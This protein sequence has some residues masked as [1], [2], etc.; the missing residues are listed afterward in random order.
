MEK[1]D[2]FLTE[3]MGECWHDWRDYPA[4]EGHKDAPEGELFVCK[5]CRAHVS[6]DIGKPFTFSTWENFGKLFLWATTQRWWIDF[7]LNQRD[8]GV[9]SFSKIIEPTKFANLIYNF[10]KD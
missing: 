8:P 10:L 1:R 7:I 4:W 6:S 9:F 2:K 3:A 5:Q